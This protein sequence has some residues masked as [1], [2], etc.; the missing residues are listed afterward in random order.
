MKIKTS[1]S[2]VSRWLG[3]VGLMV[4]HAVAVAGND[5]IFADSFESEI[6]I[7][8]ESRTLANDVPAGIPF[9]LITNPP[10][11]FK[12]IPFAVFRFERAAGTSE[13]PKST[14]AGQGTGAPEPPPAVTRS[15]NSINILQ[16][17]EINNE[18]VT[19]IEGIFQ[20]ELVAGSAGQGSAFLEF[21]SIDG[22]FIIELTNPVDDCW[23]CPEPDGSTDKPF[24]GELQHSDTDVSIQQ[25]SW[26]TVQR[27]YSSQSTHRR[28]IAKNDVGV[29]W[30][31]TFISDFLVP[32]GANVISFRD[33]NRT[34]L[35][36]ATMDPD[37]FEAPL[38]FYEELRRNSAGEFELRRDD[39]I[40]KTYAAFDDPVIPGRLIRQEDRNGNFMSFLYEEHS[41]SGKY[42]LSTAV[43]SMGRNIVFRY[44]PSDDLNT[45][46]RGRLW[47]IEDFRRDNSASG[48]ITQY[49]YD[50]EGNLTSV[51]S[52][53][54]TNTPNAN[55]F[56]VGKTKRYRYLT[57][58]TI[59]ASVVGYNRERLRSN[60]ISIEYPNETATDLDPSNAQT[61]GTPLGT[62]VSLSPMA[63]IPRTPTVLTS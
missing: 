33:S 31:F 46:R 60:L 26:F 35:F 20:G 9:V 58:A 37:V 19:D 25:N 11:Q 18:I 34:D 45:G 44:Y 38:E 5:E 36:T 40:T 61:L 59:P 63:S 53:T 10:E 2:S 57:E 13:T 49:D 47:Q 62:T 43:D 39:G 42:V 8:F 27:T 52:P 30:T 7:Q 14:S 29:D 22:G 12:E 4:I 21:D 17:G 16:N 50:S 54:V 56:P 3:F 48:R 15:F 23:P 51:R 1:T 6:I 24:S 32:D 55:D 41:G 28:A